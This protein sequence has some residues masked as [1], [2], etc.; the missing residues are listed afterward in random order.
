MRGIGRIT[1]RES[2]WELPGPSGTFAY[3]GAG[4]GQLPGARI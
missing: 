4:P 3:L 2:P 1:Q